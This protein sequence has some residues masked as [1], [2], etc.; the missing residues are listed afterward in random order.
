[1]KTRNPPIWLRKRYPGR[2][3]T[4][5]NSWRTLQIQQHWA[6]YY[7][8]F[9]TLGKTGIRIGEA[10]G[11]DWSHVDFQDRSLLVER[12]YTDRRMGPP[13]G[14]RAR[15]VDLSQETV[16]VLKQHYWEMMEL[17]LKKGWQELH[18]VFPNI[19]GGRLELSNLRN[20][21]FVKALKKAGL[22]HR[23]IHDLRHSF[24]SLLLMKGANVLY[25]SNQLGHRSVD[26][27]LQR[28]ARWIPSDD[29]KEVD[30]LDSGKPNETHTKPGVG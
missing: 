14:R 8:L 15:K 23:R 11:L 18:P 4:S 1:M 19:E 2:L 25:V 16:R 28:Y 17:K 13:K 7:P 12:S 21:V 6:F 30:R 20:R 26:I 10:M 3:N 27:T 9:F 22:S 29:R 5:P 24:A